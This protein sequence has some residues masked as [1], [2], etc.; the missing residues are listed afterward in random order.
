MRS[1]RASEFYSSRSARIG[2]LAPSA[3][4]VASRADPA[5]NRSRSPAWIEGALMLLTYDATEDDI[6]SWAGDPDGLYEQDWDIAFTGIG[7][8][9]LFIELASDDSCPKRGFFLHCLYL[10]VGDAARTQ[11]HTTSFEHLEELFAC[12]EATA[13]PCLLARVCQSRDLIANRRP[14]IY[15]LW[16]RG[17]LAHRALAD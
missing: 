3:R 13:K 5:A 12:A 9:P 14:F 4:T 2:R 10:L 17:G 7:H 1:R 6:R 15:D 8:E 16:C 11:G